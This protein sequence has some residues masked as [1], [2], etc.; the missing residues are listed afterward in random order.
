MRGR[1]MGEDT[2]RWMS[3]GEMERTRCSETIG[4]MIEHN[5]N[6]EG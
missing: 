4:A 6:V 3:E 2:E 1:E 5:E